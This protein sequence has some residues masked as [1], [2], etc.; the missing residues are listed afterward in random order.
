MDVDADIV[1]VFGG[2]NDFGHGEALLGEPADRTPETFWGATHTLFSS[3][4]EKYPEATI[5]VL[6]PLHRCSE[7]DPQG[8]HIREHKTAPLKEYVKTIREA[9]GYYGLPVLD[10]FSNSGMQPKVPI[11]K[12]KFMPDGLHPNDAGYEILYRKVSAFLKSL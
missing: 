4:I 3:L 5:V 10:L 8:D 7:D 11:I 2:T 6:T 1:V 12:E 9:A